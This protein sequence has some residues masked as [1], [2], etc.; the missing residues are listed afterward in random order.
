MDWGEN[1]VG[2]MHG[3]PFEE[4]PLHAGK[5]DRGGLVWG[6][7]EDA[8]LTGGPPH[9]TWTVP[10]K[11]GV[12]VTTG[13]IPTEGLG[14][15]GPYTFRLV[16]ETVT[17]DGMTNMPLPPGIQLDS[18]TGSISGVTLQGGE[19]HPLVET[20]AGESTPSESVVGLEW[21]TIQVPVQ[22]TTHLLNQITGRPIPNKE[23]HLF[24][25]ME[26]AGMP[27]STA[28]TD[29]R[30]LVHFPN[31]EPMTY[32]VELPAQ[33]GVTGVGHTCQWVNLAEFRAMTRT[34][35]FTDTLPNGPG[36]VQIPLFGAVW[37][38]QQAQSKFGLVQGG[39]TV[40]FG[41]LQ[42]VGERHFFDADITDMHLQGLIGIDETIDIRESPDQPSNGQ[43]NITDLGGQF[44][45]D[46]FFDIWTEIS[47]DGGQTR[48]PSEQPTRH[49]DANPTHAFPPVGATLTG[50]D[51]VS[52][53]PSAPQFVEIYKSILVLDPT[54]QTLLMLGL[55]HRE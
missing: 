3:E 45:V 42:T 1:A 9:R 46:S 41:P 15:T 18:V 27:V 29:A 24:T 32:T 48:V 51:T 28:T 36:T 30:K 7:V 10:A 34:V 2:A 47:L 31:L 12:P 44:Q 21:S 35:F 6:A 50:Q 52:G 13:E 33:T 40:V 22:I 14:G 26:C 38:T 53:P 55:E 23:M 43:I 39:A 5:D 49:Q 20:V 4:D 16:H 11:P 8:P 25:G 54:V 37:G 17:I 19:Y